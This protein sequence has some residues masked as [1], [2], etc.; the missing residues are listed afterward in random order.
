ML[1]EKAGGVR[2]D[3]E[4]RGVAERD[5]SRVAE[6]QVERQREQRRDGDLARELQIRGRDEERQERRQPEGDLG[7]APAD[8]RREKLASVCQTGPPDATSAVQ[9]SPDRSG[10]PRARGSSTC[11]PCR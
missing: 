11:P 1:G 7:P 8:L 10:M 9:P 5:D 3:A 2:A 6:D 4:I